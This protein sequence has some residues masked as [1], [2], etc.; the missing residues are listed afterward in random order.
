MVLLVVLATT[1]AII[2]ATLAPQRIAVSGEPLPWTA[3]PLSRSDGRTRWVLAHSTV[4]AG[5]VR[6]DPRRRKVAIG[7]A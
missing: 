7:D 1:G 6:E 5:S 2:A 3:E 4:R